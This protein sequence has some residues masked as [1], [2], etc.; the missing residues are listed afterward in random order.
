MMKRNNL[1]PRRAQERQDS[2]ILQEDHNAMANLS[3]IPINREWQR[4]E[5][6]ADVWNDTI[7]IHPMKS[8]AKHDPMGR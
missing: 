4:P 1:D 2:R 3:P 7:Y 8:I 5:E 6:F